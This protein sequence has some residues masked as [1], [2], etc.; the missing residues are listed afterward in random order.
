MDYLNG[1]DLQRNREESVIT[2]SKLKMRIVESE[3]R[4]GDFECYNKSVGKLVRADR[5]KGFT[6]TDEGT[7]PLTLLP[8]KSDGGEIII[9]VMLASGCYYK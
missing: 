9:F 4:D 6:R 2:E 1:S 3:D 8:N 5:D 7:P